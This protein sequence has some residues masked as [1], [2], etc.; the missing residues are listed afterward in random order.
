MAYV[1]TDACVSCGTCEGECPVGAISMGDGKYEID[2]SACVDLGGR[3]VTNTTGAIVL[4]VLVHA[5]L[6]LLSS[7]YCQR[8]FVTYK[9]CR[10]YRID[11]FCTFSFSL[12]LIGIQFAI[13]A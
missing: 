8:H 7:S 1:I 13:T 11:M 4:L 2:A 10:S 9:R 3:R 6:V 5:L 12:C